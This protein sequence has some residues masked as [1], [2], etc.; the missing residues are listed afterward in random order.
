MKNQLM[1]MLTLSVF[2]TSL[3][4]QVRFDSTDFMYCE[5]SDPQC[6]SSTQQPNPDIYPYKPYEVSYINLRAGLLTE[7]Q[8]YVKNIFEMEKRGLNQRDTTHRPWGGPYWAQI[9]RAHV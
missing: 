2:S 5:P 3:F 1:L 4:A 9:G 8:S 7:S 6:E